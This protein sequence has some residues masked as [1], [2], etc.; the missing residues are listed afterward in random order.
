MK[1]FNSIDRQVSI[2]PLV[3][4]RIIFGLIMSASTIRFM[5]NGWVHD[6]YVSPKVYFPFYGFEWVKPLPELGMYLLFFSLIISFLFIA[7]GAFYRIATAYSFLAFTYIELIDKTN[8]LNHYYFVSIFCLLLI[9]LPANKSFSVDVY[10]KPSLKSEKTAWGNILILQLQLAI[11]YFFAGLAKLNPDWLFE[12]M[13]LKIWLPAQA[14]IWLI[15]PMLAKDWVAYAFSWG[16]AIYD[17]SIP[18]FLFYKPTRKYAYLLVIVFHLLTWFLF[19]I[20]MFPFIMIGATLIFF[21]AEFHQQTIDFLQ[22]I[23]G[24]KRSQFV[25]SIPAKLSLSTAK[26]VFFS[27]FLILQVLIPLRHLAYPGDLFWTEQGYRFSWR[28]MLMEKAGYTIFH[29]TDPSSNRS[30]EVNNYDFLTPVQEKMMSTQADMILQFAHHLEGYY[31]S[32]GISNPKITAESYVSLNGSAS[33]L[34]I[35]PKLDL[36]KVSDSF[37]PKDWILSPSHQIAVK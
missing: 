31:Q 23:I 28:V 12:A 6:L 16:G 2:A 11:V 10:R 20:G 3:M 36:T 9:F 8:Y 17:L 1:F 27:T 5:A 30:W 22:R 14:D 35:D 24:L 32:H 13:P 21:S 26:K 19:N 4:I 37:S 29:I 25:D 18:F 33:R 15:G 7:A 34:Y